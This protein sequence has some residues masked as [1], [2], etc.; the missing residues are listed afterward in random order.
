MLFTYQSYNV[1]GL[2]HIKEK[3][4][5]EMNEMDNIILICLFCFLFCVLGLYIFIS[6]EETEWIE[7]E[8]EIRIVS[9]NSKQQTDG[10]FYGSIFVQSGHLDE[11]RYYQVILKNKSDGKMLY[12]KLDAE[13]TFIYE[14]DEHE[15][16]HINVTWNSKA[17]NT[18]DEL[19]FSD[20]F[21]GFS[22]INGEIIDISIHIPKGTIDQT[23]QLD[24]KK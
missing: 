4:M 22:E 6:S 1:V 8:E 17:D 13:D 15:A 2:V 20:D 16:P 23:F 10:D 9:F 11:K 12:Y 5:N 24:L 19:Y 14:N 3:K 21:K 7:I 18:D